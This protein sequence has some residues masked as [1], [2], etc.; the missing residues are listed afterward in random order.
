MDIEKVPVILDADKLDIGKAVEFLKTHDER[1]D[2]GIE[3]KYQKSKDERQDEKIR[4]YLLR[5]ESPVFHAVFHPAFLMNP[6]GK[7]PADG[8]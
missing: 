3:K 8:Y 2:E 1:T 7:C 6:Q 4:R 5:T